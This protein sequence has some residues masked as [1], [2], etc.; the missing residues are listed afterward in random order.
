MNKFIEPNIPFHPKGLG[1]GYLITVSNTTFYHAGD[2]DVIE[3]MN[4]LKE[5]ID[6]A[7][8]P[9]SGTYVMTPKEGIKCANIIKPKLSIPMH[10]G[11]IVG[12][13]KD[14]EEFSSNYNGKSQ[15]PLK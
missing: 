4:A 10:F 7:F 3:E 6:V 2:T 1:I 13:V 11:S 8:L 9:I 5:K 15:I 14:A 12:S